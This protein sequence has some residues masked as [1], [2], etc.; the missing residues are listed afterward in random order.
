RS[1]LLEIVLKLFEL[2]RVVPNIILHN[3]MIKLTYDTTDD[4]F[5]THIRRAE[6]AKSHTTE[7]LAEFGDDRGLAHARRLH[8]RRHTAGSAAV[9]AN[10]RID[11]FNGAKQHI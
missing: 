2:P 1:L 11:D 4:R 8:R 7:M 3:A 6:T 10:V 9:N 5:V